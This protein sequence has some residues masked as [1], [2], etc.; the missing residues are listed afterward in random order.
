MA[1]HEPL[2]AMLRAGADGLATKM[3]ATANQ[4]TT[5]K[6]SIKLVDLKTLIIGIAFRTGR[7]V[8]AA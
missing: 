7:R 5:A 8:F 4:W 1:V 2:A 3:V 6:W